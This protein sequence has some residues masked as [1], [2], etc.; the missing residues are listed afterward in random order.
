MAHD[1]PFDM[2][3]LMAFH[4]ILEHRNVTKAAESLGLSQPAMSSALRRL[5]ER[6]DDPLFVRSGLEMKPTARATEL[7]VAVNQVVGT[8]KAEIL[9]PVKFDCSTSRRTF[10]LLAPDIAEANLLPDILR[11]LSTSAPG[12]NLKTLGNPRHVAAESLA[13]GLADLAIG[14]FPDLQRA[15]FYR[16]RLL[17]SKHVCLARAQHPRSSGAMGLTDFLQE[18]HVVVRPEGRMH[19]FE[20]HLI[21]KGLSLNIRL[22]VSHF[23][24]LL[25]VL[26]STDL[27]ATVPADLARLCAGYGDLTMFEPPLRI[28][29]TDVNIYWHP[30]VQKDPGHAWLRRTI[31][32]LF[33]KPS[34]VEATPHDRS[35]RERL[36]G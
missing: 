34:S 13:S 10:T 22:V 15:G 12:I 19:M 8:V 20:N 26:E 1:A 35:R 31:H 5:R 24:C 2:N 30:R 16:Q 14:Y 36:P 17:H 32:T 4:A 29:N 7:G 18:A 11:T 6:F 23:L 9:A 21:E 28:P 33:A 25:P 27:I 3:L